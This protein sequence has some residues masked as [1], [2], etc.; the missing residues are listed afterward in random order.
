VLKLSV[1]VV[2]KLVLELQA[3]AVLA[4]EPILNQQQS[5]DCMPEP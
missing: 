1:Q 2:D 3:T 4:A 5:L